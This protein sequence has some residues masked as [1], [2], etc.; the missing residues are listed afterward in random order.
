MRDQVSHTEGKI[1]LQGRDSDHVVVRWDESVHAPVSVNLRQRLPQQV[2]IR[3]VYNWS[4]FL[5]DE[6]AA[7][8]W[9]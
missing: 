4:I 6:L 9:D 5:V 8:R 2:G 7:F 1:K 3:R